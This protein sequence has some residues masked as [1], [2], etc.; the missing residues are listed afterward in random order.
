MSLFGMPTRLGITVAISTWRGTE[1]E[2]APGICIV[3]VPARGMPSESMRST[4]TSWKIG[5]AIVEP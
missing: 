1:T 4:A 5:A 3:R 2:T